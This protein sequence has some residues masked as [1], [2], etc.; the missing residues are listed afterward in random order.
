MREQLATIISFKTMRI[1]QEVSGS[2][3]YGNDSSSSTIWVVQHY[4]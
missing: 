3:Y 1:P 4:Q 2:I